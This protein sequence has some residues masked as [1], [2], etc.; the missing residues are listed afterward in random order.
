MVFK[1]LKEASF[2]NLRPVSSSEFSVDIEG[3][4]WDI[5]TGPY[6]RTKSNIPSIGLFMYKNSLAVFYI[7]ILIALG[8]GVAE[9]LKRRR[10]GAAD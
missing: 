9:F 8:P 2:S 7:S 5:R 3:V 1:G 10:K 6:G 4:A